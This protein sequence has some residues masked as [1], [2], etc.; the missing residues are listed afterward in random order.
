MDTWTKVG[1]SPQGQAVSRIKHKV[2]AFVNNRLYTTDGNVVIS[3]DMRTEKWTDDRISIPVGIKALQLTACA[4]T[5]FAVTEEEE[6]DTGRIS[7]WGLGILSH[8]FSL[9]VEMPG[10]IR[11]A[12]KLS[13]HSRAKLRSVGHGQHLFFWRHNSLRIASYDV[14]TREWR[15]LPEIVV[16]ADIVADDGPQIAIDAGFFEPKVEFQQPA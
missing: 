2:C 10:E 9:T 4:G 1:C 16:Q 14:V 3:F 6:G 8:R 15:Q 5:L 7:V 11:G 13:R 12:L